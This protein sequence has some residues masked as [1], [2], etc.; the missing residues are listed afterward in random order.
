[1]TKRI[2]E[3]FDDFEDFES[4]EDL[5]SMTKVFELTTKSAA[6]LNQETT[7]IVEEENETSKRDETTKRDETKKPDENTEETTKKQVETTKRQAETTKSQ[8]TTKREMTTTRAYPHRT[9]VNEILPRY[10]EVI[11]SYPTFYQMTFDEIGNLNSALSAN[12]NEVKDNL[13]GQEISF[14]NK[15]VNGIVYLNYEYLQQYIEDYTSNVKQ[16]YESLPVAPYYSYIMN[17]KFNYDFKTYTT[18]LRMKLDFR[19]AK[20]QGLYFEIPAKIYEPVDAKVTENGYYNV[21]LRVMKRAKVGFTENFALTSLL[22][23][24]DIECHTKHNPFFDIE[25]VIGPA[26]TILPVMKESGFDVTTMIQEGEFN[27]III[28]KKGYVTGLY[29]LKS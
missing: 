23:I 1:M 7:T 14:D 9:S 15:R 24:L 8:E 25:E 20:N 5:D 16:S 17:D 19:S 21:A 6:S 12:Y 4:D 10:K 28:D 26:P 2:V 11:Y 29:A 13:W 27:Y 22:E 18:N 3:D